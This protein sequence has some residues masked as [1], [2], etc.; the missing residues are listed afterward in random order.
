MSGSKSSEQNKARSRLTDIVVE[1]V[2]LVDRAANKHRFLIVKRSD[3]MDENSNQ[4]VT[5][6][7]VTDSTEEEE[8]ITDLNE[9]SDA[10][11]P[12]PDSPLGVA[13]GLLEGLTEAVELLSNA[14]EN[15]AQTT[16]AMVAD[17]LKSASDRL[18]QMTGVA[19]HK[20]DDQSEGDTDGNGSGSDDSQKSDLSSSIG[21]V[22]E[23]LQRVKTILES[24]SKGD[25]PDKPPDQSPAA[26]DNS[27]GDQLIKVAKELRTL[28]NAVKDQQQRLT[29]LEKRFGIPGS[30]PTNEGRRCRPEDDDVGWPLDLNR[31]CD[32]ESVDKSVSF[33]DV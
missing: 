11:T 18:A 28:T 10:D 21:A 32:R 20:G 2:S 7:D 25:T 6:T 27:V 13:V 33:H 17:E 5:E 22:R 29:K 26:G 16:L 3:E 14:D 12:D 24:S 31:Y 15:E 30:V 19:P 23:T 9:S 1:E 4:Q 8:V